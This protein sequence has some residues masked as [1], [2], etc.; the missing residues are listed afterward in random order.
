MKL[1]VCYYPEHWPE[2]RWCVDAEQ[3]RS[4]GISI[5]RIAEFAW[6]KMELQEGVFDW[7]WLDRAIETLA[8]QGLQVVLGTPTAAPPAWMVRAY[9][10]VLPVDAQGRRREFGSRCHHC[11][12]SPNY[13][14]LTEHIVRA[15][16][17]RYGQHAGVIAWQIDNEFGCH[18]TVR[19][20]CEH[21]AAAFRVWLEKRYGSLEA[22]NEAWGAVFWSQT[23]TDWAQIYPPNLTVTVPNCAHV[24]DY[25]RFSSDS[26]VAYQQLQLDVLRPWTDG[27]RMTTNF[28]GDSPDLDYYDMARPLDLI[29]WDSYPTGQQE[30]SSTYLYPEWEPRPMFTY[31]AGDPYI[32][33]YNHALMRGL[34]RK[35]FWVMEQQCG[36]IN[37]GSYNPVMRA[38]TVRLWSWHA[39]AC[40]AEAVVYFRWRA[41]RFAQE[42]YHSGLLHHDASPDQGYREVQR[43]NA[44]LPVLDALPG[45]QPEPQVAIVYNYVDLWALQLQPHRKG[46]DYR[47]LVFLYHR[48]LQTLGIHADIVPYDADLSRYKLVIAPVSFVTQPQQVLAL[49]KYVRE[50]GTALLGVRSGFKLPSN[51]VTADPLPGLWRG[52]V[53]A[54]VSDWHALP[55]QITYGLESGID[56]LSGEA[57]VW[58]EALLPME[59]TSVWAH[60]S[61]GPLA[62]QAAL[63]ERVYGAGRVL[64]LGWYPRLAQA[65]TLLHWLADQV[66]I[67]GLLDLAEGVVAIQR[68]ERC[69]LL[70][71]SPDEQV[72]EMNGQRFVLPSREILVQ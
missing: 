5:V 65:R 36:P 28:M 2:E 10:D 23:Y 27:R 67:A 49:Q 68:G 26:L 61:D 16:G 56:G 47:G 60:Y 34:L 12:N 59:G 18:E 22:L 38:G 41:C 32:A 46:F 53:G 42:Q 1:G 4:I 9:P 17:E 63:C 33:G 31:D 45:T 62:G 20:Y 8:A 70:N 71:F 44:E 24:L 43:L 25:E 7:G 15:M 66:H 3:M 50:G 69:V 39:A 57:E 6:Y 14:R 40:G 29:T 54:T 19:C 35:P 21:C 48:A 58:A 51:Q 11:S 52:M 30:Y 55:P 37:W 13:L 72:V 64:Y